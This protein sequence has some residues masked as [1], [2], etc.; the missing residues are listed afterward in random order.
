[1]NNQIKD[2]N[3]ESISIPKLSNKPFIFGVCS[4]VFFILSYLAIN[5][6]SIESSNIAILVS[7]IFLLIG[8]STL[9]KFKKDNKE[10][11]GS[12]K[13]KQARL[14]LI[15]SSV[16]IFIAA[17]FVLIRIIYFVFFFKGFGRY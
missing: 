5:F 7:F 9:R 17:I 4:I 12:K 8:F 11:F 1:M 16:L 14:T 3:I 2:K 6:L 13:Y 10:F 15:I